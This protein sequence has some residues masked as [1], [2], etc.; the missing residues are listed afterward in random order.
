[1]SI[2]HHEVEP[3]LSAA[4]AGSGQ[5]VP[6]SAETA[7][8]PQRWPLGTTNLRYGGDYNPEQWTRETWIEDI[9]LMKHAGINL[10]S[11]GI[12]SW[13]LLEPREGEYDFSFLDDI[14]GL[15]ADAHID[16]DLGTPT[17]SPPAWF[18]AKYP[19]SRPVTRDGLPLGFGSRGM[20]S[21]SSPEY[22]RAVAAIAGQL[23]AR[24]AKHPALVMWHVHNEYGAPVS[25][26]YSEHSVVAFRQWLQVRYGS[27]DALNTGWGTTFWG[28]RYGEWSEV[29]APRTSASVTNQTQRLDFKR[30]SSD[31]LL[32]CYTTE[33]D[34]LRRFTPH[35]PVTTNFMVTNCP[36]VDYWK[37]AK[38]VDV[39][40]N[41]HYLKAERRDNHIL[42]SMD[43]D[44]SR[45]LAR[46]E[47]WILMEHSTSA[48]NWQPRNIA[49]RAG[50][51]ARNSLAHLARGA[52][53]IM[54]FQ[55]RASRYGA[56]K[57]HSA[58]LP[59]A[60]Q[61]SRVWREVVELGR[62]LGSLLAVR[63]SRVHARVA[64]L[65]DVESFWAQDLEWHPSADLDHRERIEAFYT[66]LWRR[67]VTIDF[68]HPHDDLSAYDLV[69]APS[70]Y[71]IDQAGADS[72]RSYVK[73]GGRLLVSYFSGIVDENDAVH[74]GPYPGAIADVL[75]I[76]IEEFLPFYAHQVATLDDG[77][78]ATVWADDL[79]LVTADAVVSFV[80]GP[81]SG[82]PAITRNAFGEGSAWYVATRLDPAGLD[83]L[84]DAVLRDAGIIST[85]LP[86]GLE[87]VTRSHTNTS[88][89]FY[90]NHSASDAEVDS[91]GTEL[92][93]GTRHTGTVVVPAATVRVVEN[94]SA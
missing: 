33:R 83:S 81:A 69:L 42:L 92:I 29:D 93:T 58:M 80:D 10:V 87:V 63:G 24:Y 67:G 70:L 25:E 59:H 50:Q 14:M 47:P 18:F 64:I 56:E 36:S 77:S 73:G 57:F 19:E 35:L 75:G 4:P 49:K 7:P 22:R 17:A 66:V 40:A 5:A 43:A 16:V 74:D 60:G 32:A 8:F 6:V 55:F 41:D 84:I 23:A 91:T 27:L 20:A 72:I 46:S 3:A 52:D 78:T 38:E 51:M 15:L 82:I 30:F 48:V 34:V 61:E 1:M 11:I 28:Q 39:V 13:A 68:A 45:S 86:D 88:F 62:D 71:L 79:A 26:C 89:T 2:Q 90:I 44:L 94:A 85:P 9:E 54:F 65:W 53:G 76:R 31:A 37:W 21:P 12:F